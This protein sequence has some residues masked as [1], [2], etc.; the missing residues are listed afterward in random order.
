MARVVTQ[1]GRPHVTRT[2]PTYCYGSVEQ[3]EQIIV[4]W[5]VQICVDHMN[6]IRFDLQ[7]IFS[8]TLSLMSDWTNSTTRYLT[9]V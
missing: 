7:I 9:C 5:D 1:I 3:Y 4:R 6:H 8:A 2:R